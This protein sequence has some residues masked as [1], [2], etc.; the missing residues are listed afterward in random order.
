MALYAAQV[1]DIWDNQI[2]G[3]PAAAMPSLPGWDVLGQLR[4][5]DDLDLAQSLRSAFNLPQDVCFYG[6][7]LRR[8]DGGDP[9]F[10]KGDY[11]AMVRGTGSNKEWF[12]DA[13]AF[14]EKLKAAAARPGGLVPA[15]FHSIYQSMVYIDAGGADRGPAAHALSDVVALADK[16]LTVVGHSL[17]AALVAYLAYDLATP[18]VP[19]SKVNSYMFAS[20]NPGDAGFAAAVKQNVQQY[21]V[22]NW[23][24]DVVPKLPPVPF[25]PLLN[26][27]AAGG[28]QVV[29]VMSPADL[30]GAWAPKDCPTCNH[31]AVCYARM[32]DPDNAAAKAQTQ[33]YCC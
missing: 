28:S 13:C 25:C 24:C 8:A 3:R 5:D 1:E 11:L 10:D 32:L 27:A 18:P 19:C 12:L 33:D 23:S 15:G 2:K 20:P 22:V 31:H 21:T 7:L 6:L 17:G 30:V 14:P 9:D 26:N 16:P 29:A 4:A